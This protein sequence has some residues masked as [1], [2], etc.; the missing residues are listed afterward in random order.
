MEII[1]LKSQKDL[2]KKRIKAS[3]E[4]GELKKDDLSKL[5][6][7]EKE[8]LLEMSFDIYSEAINTH[9]SLAALEY[10]LFSAIRILTLKAERK[11]LNEED[12]KIENSLNGI[13]NMHEITNRGL[14][15][16]D[17]SE[18]YLSYLQEVTLNTMNKRKEFKLL[19]KQLKEGKDEE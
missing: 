19:K 5:T 10:T 12:R 1:Q 3:I 18:D 9:R 15:I 17:W 6:D 4:N 7:E 16:E 13:L 2:F 8:M 11:V 14:S